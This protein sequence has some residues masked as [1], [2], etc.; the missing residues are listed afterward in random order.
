MTYTNSH[1]AVSLDELKSRYHEKMQAF[2]SAINEEKTQAEINH[3]YQELKIIQQELNLAN[4]H[5]ELKKS[6]EP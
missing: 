1:P 2:E 4:L 5:E 6:S 3:L